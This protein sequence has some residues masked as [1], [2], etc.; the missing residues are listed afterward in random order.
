M[1]RI[2]CGNIGSGKTASEVREL[3]YNLSGRKTYT[4]IKTDFPY[5]VELK[6]EYIIKKTL[7]KTKRTG[8]E[9]FKLSFNKK[10]WE[11]NHE[12]INVTF[13]EISAIYDAR[14]S[15]SK[16]NVI[17]SQFQNSLRRVLGN[18]DAGTGELVYITQWIESIDPR[19]RMACT[20]I[21][22]HSCD[23]QKTCKKCGCYWF[24][25]SDDPEH[26]QICPHCFSK[27]LLKHN[28]S[29]VVKKFGFKDEITAEQNFF[30][31]RD[32]GEETYY[33]EYTIEDIEQYFPH[34]NTLQ[35]ENLFEDYY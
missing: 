10:F 31:W 13:D 3:F 2:S 26:L 17:F 32:F 6:P 25:N 22:H 29:V 21:R 28:H 4:N 20:Q 1:I 30:K 7:V 35:W 8:E 19:A 12:P 16:L 18:T 24:E 23:Y 5:C 15:M 34:Y 11:E 27:D 14:R 9:V 33:D